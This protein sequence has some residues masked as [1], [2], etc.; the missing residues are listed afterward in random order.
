MAGRTPRGRSRGLLACGGAVF[1]RLLTGQRG[2]TVTAVVSGVLIMG[3]GAGMV[4][5]G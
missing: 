4:M 2:R 1:G 5:G 3:M